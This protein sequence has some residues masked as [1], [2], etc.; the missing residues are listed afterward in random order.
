MAKLNQL[1]QARLPLAPELPPLSQPHLSLHHQLKAAVLPVR[2]PV[3]L[4]VVLELLLQ[5]QPPL[6]LHQ[7]RRLRERNTRVGSISMSDH[8]TMPRRCGRGMEIF[9]RLVM[10]GIR[11]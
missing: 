3:R 7:Q 11:L 4:P 5:R 1:Q 8:E 10:R 6:L 2:L 9:P